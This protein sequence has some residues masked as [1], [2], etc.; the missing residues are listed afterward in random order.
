[1]NQRLLIWLS[2]T[3]VTSV[4]MSVM[5]LAHQTSQ[6][7]AIPAASKLMLVAAQAPALAASVPMR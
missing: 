4:V 1:M 6:I 5:W 2:R 7:P 3:I